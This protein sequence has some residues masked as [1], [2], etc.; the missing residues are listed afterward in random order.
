MLAK[1]TTIAINLLFGCGVL[2]SQHIAIAQIVPDNTLPN[3]S[4]VFT[5][6]NTNVIEGGTQTGSNLFHSFDV[7]SIPTGG[8]AYFNN[9][10]DIQNIISRVTGGSVSNIDGLIQANG[11]ANLFLLNSNGIIFGPNA[12]LNIGGSFLASTAR[13]LNFADGNTFV[14]TD[15][16]NT[17]LLTVSVP[18]GLNFGSNPG[19]ISVQGNGHQLR[20]ANPA[21]QVGSPITGASQSLTGLRTAPQKTLALLGGEVTF[22]GG[23]ITA[24]SGQIEVGSVADGVVDLSFTPLGFS[25]NYNQVSKFKNIQLDKKALLDASG[26]LNGQISVRGE[27]LYLQGG[28]LV[29]V[30]SLGDFNSGKINIEVA[31]SVLLTGVTEPQNFDTNTNFDLNSQEII[32][33]IYT[34][35]FLNSKGADINIAAKELIL[36]QFSTISTNSYG[37]GSGG[38][39]SINLKGD[40]KIFGSPPVQFVFLPSYLSTFSFSSGK[41]GNLD[42]S[43]NSLYIKDGGLLFSQTLNSGKGGSIEA[44]FLENVEIVG[45]FPID[46]AS[47]SFIPSTLGTAALSSGN[48]GD[49]FINTQRLS[50]ENGGRIGATTAALG[51]GGSITI[52]ANDLVEVKGKVIGSTGNASYNISQISS[53]AIKNNL[54]LNQLFTLSD[55]PQGKAGFI[56]I[57]TKKVIIQNEGQVSVINKGLGNA[58]ETIINSPLI[59]L[60][61]QGKITAATASGEGGEIFLQSDNL[62]LRNGSNITATAGGSGNGG[63]ININTDL[64]TL[65]QA[66]KITAD[67]VAGRGGNIEIATQGLFQSPDSP[68]TASSDLGIDGTVEI[69]TL[70]NQPSNGTLE[71]PQQ[72]IDSSGLIAQ[73]CLG[74]VAGKPSSFV[75][76]GRGGKA[77]T[78]FDPLEAEEKP[79]NSL[80]LAD[81]PAGETKPNNEQ[82][83][84]SKIKS[85]LEEEPVSLVQADSWQYNSKGEIVLFASNKGIP[86]L[87]TL[88]CRASK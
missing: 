88:E 78:P 11:T 83:P 80:G 84:P 75:I 1:I 18:I 59:L 28:S 81:S 25:F 58:G 22:N 52:K 56:E 42:L 24:P 2:I 21:A 40:L 26:F 73:G 54:F 45:S 13:S 47:N 82:L 44:K 33:G 66:S 3:N 37:E 74:N 50:I 46:L 61:T 6:E 43:G 62:Q 30:S 55:L 14:T 8:G 87:P 53:S 35:N 86:S 12:K 63:S 23:I 19:K 69:N 5:Q 20:F 71:L 27:N 31:D 38:D 17:P 70:I 85:L 65:T 7:F 48:A 9:A 67:A 16:Q 36:Q 57:T 32:R 15:S 34:Q 4:R 60:N 64:L 51:A 76:T 10:S 41:A 77:P 39:I 79:L 29:L 72:I 68:I 49:V